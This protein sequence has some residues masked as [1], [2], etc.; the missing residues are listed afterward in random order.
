MLSIATDSTCC[1]TSQSARAC[2]SSVV[3]PELRMLG[4]ASVRAGPQTQCSAL[5]ISMPAHL[6]PHA[7]ATPWASPV[8][9]LL[10]LFSCS[11]IATSVVAMAAGPE[12]HDRG[13]SDL[14][15]CRRGHTACLANERWPA[16]T[17][18]INGAHDSSNG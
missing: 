9:F 18:T 12:W 3:V 7:R 13:D 14:G 2:S 17:Q 5:P 4:V 10:L 16:R 15:E 11:T 1:A 6:R 8:R